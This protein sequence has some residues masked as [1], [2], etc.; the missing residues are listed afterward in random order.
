M[1][2]LAAVLA[3][4]SGGQQALGL[5][6][7][8]VKTLDA[9]NMDASI[10]QQYERGITYG[11]G[12]LWISAD[13]FGTKVELFKVD[14]NGEVIKKWELGTDYGQHISDVEYRDGL[15]W[16]VTN[17]GYLC[18]FD[19]ETEIIEIRLSFDFW[20]KGLT[21]DGQSWWMVRGTGGWDNSMMEIDPVTGEIIKECEVM[22]T[23]PVANPM[24]LTWDG[25]YI[26]LAIRETEGNG[27]YIIRVI[28]PVDCAI[29]QDFEA[30]VQV[31]ATGVAFDGS[32]IWT[33]SPWL[34]KLFT[35]QAVDSD[36]DGIG[37]A[38]DCAPDDPLS[39]GDAPEE[40]DGK[41]N[42]CDGLLD[43]N[44]PGLIVPSM[45]CEK[46]DGNC[47]NTFKNASHCKWGAWQPCSAADYLAVFPEYSDV[48]DTCDGVDNNCDGLEDDGVLT[49]GLDGTVYKGTGVSCGI[50][51]CKG[52]FIDCSEDGKSSYCTS[53][54]NAAPEICDGNDNDCDGKADSADPVDLVANDPHLCDNQVGACA[55]SI[56]GANLCINGSWVLTCDVASYQAS[57]DK[58]EVGEEVT[59]DGLDNDCDGSADEDFV[60]VTLDGATVAGVG[61]GCG[62][63]LCSGGVTACLA[64]KSGTTC[65]TNGKAAPEVC[66]NKDNDCDGKTDAQD[67]ADLKAADKTACEN[68]N[69]VCNGSVKPPALCVGGNWLGCGDTQYQNFSAAYQAKVE[70]T[71]EGLDNDCDGTA[72]EDFTVTLLDGSQVS[73][74]GTECGTGACAGGGTQCRADGSGIYC[75][76]EEDPAKE[77]CDGVDNDCDGKLDAADPVDLAANDAPFCEKQKGVCSGAAKPV[78]LCVNG[79]WSQCPPSRYAEHSIQYQHLKELTCEGLD[80]DCDGSIDEDFTVTLLNGESVTGVAKGCGVGSCAGGITVC[81]ADSAGIK[82]STE[83][84]KSNELCDGADNDCDGKTDAQDAADLLAFDKKACENQNGVC[85]GSTKGAA[86]CVAGAWGSCTNTEY[87]AYSGNYQAGAETKC[88][89]LDNDCDGKVDDDF[90]MT[91]LNGTQVSGTGTAC[92]VGA[93]AG[94]QTAC[95]GAQNGIICSSESKAA[96]EKC[97]GIDNDCDGKLDA[98]DPVDLLTNNLTNCE[99]QAGVC[100]GVT[101]PA[102]LCSG[103]KWQ[104]CGTDLYVAHSGLYQAGAETSCDASDNDCD[105][106]VD[107]DFSHTQLNGGVVTGA[108]KSCGVG[109]CAGG[110]TVCNAGK[111]G[112]YCSTETNPGLEICDGAD[113][114]CD[115]KTDASDP[116]DLLTNDTR[117][118]ENQK[119]V[120]KNSTKPAA[121]CSGGAWKACTNTEYQSFSGSFQAGKETSCDALDNDCDGN[122]DEDFT[123][124]LLNGTSVGFNVPCGVGAC[125]GGVTACNAAKNGIVCPTESKAGNEKCNKVDDD[126]DGKIDAADPTDLLKY[127]KRNCETQT[128]SCAGVT[129]GADKCVNGS[130]KNCAYDNDKDGHAAVASCGTNANDH[131]DSNAAAWKA[132]STDSDGD[133]YAPKD[134][135]PGGK[136]TT[137]CNDSC[138]TCY[139]GS[140]KWT[141]SGDGKDQDCD[142]K[143]DEWDL[144]SSWK[145]TSGTGNVKE[146]PL[147]WAE[148][149]G[150]FPGC[151]TCQG[152]RASTN[153]Q[154]VKNYWGSGLW[155]SCSSSY[156]KCTGSCQKS[157]SGGT[158]TNSG[159]GFYNQNQCRMGMW[160]AHGKWSGFKPAD[161]G[162]NNHLCFCQSWWSWCY[163]CN[164]N[165]SSSCEGRTQV[166]GVYRR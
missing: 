132:N 39:H 63:G 123:V 25:K 59:C 119:G 45:K 144:N 27:G 161:G 163:W 65:S 103:G 157:S 139:P 53:E 48:D 29:F 86:L 141:C 33:V 99:K 16:F 97:D 110:T 104:A 156:D 106:S 52:G 18:T 83:Y 133:G 81:T 107:E 150:Q 57:S 47:M 134:A 165:C 108:G 151:A 46:K 100:A 96:G 128:G 7:G 31:T 22:S 17:F 11:D 69:G 73:G 10:N 13:D 1:T 129:K 85:N 9:P 127:D 67:A 126:C 44:D 125:A 34:N 111:N 154:W 72:D 94:G 60:A 51:K 78:S 101:K 77:I 143:V 43:S 42:D 136:P 147:A 71:C 68:Q 38:V 135:C 98:A 74:V 79:K 49:V 149:T 55:G 87:Q 75:P 56:M 21:W 116:T 66:D 92:G 61:Q 166:R 148:R 36:G 64:D 117:A 80:N 89:G 58:Y 82:C 164:S 37:D 130:W 41:D 12:H 84:K 35:V 62:V 138:K 160:V 20:P 113:N 93:C 91:T 137:D 2:F 122:Y 54:L 3:L 131:C 30:A 153:C 145:N 4:L 88:E 32:Y 142:G 114:D 14:P 118:C 6:G 109:S 28:N 155:Q 5:G 159:F 19:P 15:I 95:N 90:T 24:G 26:Y 158:W 121:L 140:S 120:C 162:W 76:A 102:S 105:G 40:C 146:S 23:F 112:I 124:T 8:L 115:G 70:T 50:G 152:I